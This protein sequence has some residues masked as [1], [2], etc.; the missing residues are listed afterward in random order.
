MSI[1]IWI[2]LVPVLLSLAAVANGSLLR[3]RCH[4]LREASE[5]RESRAFRRYDGWMAWA[6]DEA[7][8]AAFASR[9]PRP[10]LAGRCE[11]LRAKFRRTHVSAPTPAAA[12]PAEPPRLAGALVRYFS[13]V[14]IAATGLVNF[15]A[16]GIL[17]A[18]S[19]AE[20]LGDPASYPDWLARLFT[21]PA[22]LLSLA[23]LAGMVVWGILALE[24]AGLVQERTFESPWMLP[25]SF[26]FLGVGAFV[27]VKSGEVRGLSG[28][29]TGSTEGAARLLHAVG[30]VKMDMAVALA[31]LVS[32]TSVI[33][34]LALK[35]LVANSVA[36]AVTFVVGASSLMLRAFVHVRE[37]LIR[38]GATLLDLFLDLARVPPLS[39]PA[40]DPAPEAEAEAAPD[41]SEMRGAA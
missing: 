8:H 25:L 7:L 23:V 30:A 37:W 26:T 22:L 5:A 9:A 21:A 36:L 14:F 1:L 20:Y 40:E 27:V 3:R 35:K 19:Y 39:L 10:T 38:A 11:S 32:A 18:L 15:A 17:V 28:L 31:V 41:E 6:C 4:T 16:E 13:F 33:G 34:L 24:A 29:H 12:V 2:I